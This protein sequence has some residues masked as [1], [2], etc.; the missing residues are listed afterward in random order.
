MNKIIQNRPFTHNDVEYS[1]RAIATENGIEVRVYRGDRPA[2]M[3]RYSFSWEE[4]FDFSHYH[5]DA[6]EKLMEIA[7][8][9]LR[10]GWY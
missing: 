8:D 7:E 5:G 6:V 2:N 10:R 4:G 3:C 9:H 1:T